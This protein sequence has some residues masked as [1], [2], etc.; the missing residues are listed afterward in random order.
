MA[1][2]KVRFNLKN[3]HYAVLTETENNGVISYS[4]VLP[5]LC[6]ALF[7]STSRRRAKS[8]RSTLTASCSTTASRTTAT[9]ARWRWRG[10][11][12]K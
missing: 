5:R 4:G 3:V 10:S 11:L 6:G 12:M 1:E 2:N 7:L 9:P 8:L